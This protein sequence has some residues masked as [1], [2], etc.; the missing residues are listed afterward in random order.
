[1]E[2]SIPLASDSTE[3]SVITVQENNQPQEEDSHSPHSSLTELFYDSTKI[4][5]RPAPIQPVE[6]APIQ[7]G[8]PVT[9]LTTEEE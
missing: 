4:A 1:M 6:P 2:D 5:Y 8:E 9:G 3:V 7:P